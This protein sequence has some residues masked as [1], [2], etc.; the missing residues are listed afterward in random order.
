VSGS[1][2][3]SI[4]LWEIKDFERSTGFGAS[5]EL[6]NNGDLEV[7]KV[8]KG[9]DADQRGLRE[10]DRIK[11]ASIERVRTAAELTK[12]VSKADF[13]ALAETLPA[14]QLIE[15]KGT[16][17]G[18]EE[19]SFSTHKRQSPTLSLF[20]D[21]T[22]QEWI[23]WEPR[24]NYAT[25]I[26]GDSRY[27]G[28][29]QNQMKAA[30]QNSDRFSDTEKTVF[31]SI[32][33][34]KQEFENRV[35][36]D[37]LVENKPEPEE[38]QPPP[39]LFASPVIET[40]G[41]DVFIHLPAE[42]DNAPR[43]AVEV[44]VNSKSLQVDPPN[45]QVVWE[46]LATGWRGKIDKEI[47]K[48]FAPNARVW[49][50]R[51]DPRSPSDAVTVDVEIQAPMTGRLVVFGCGAAR[52]IGREP[53]V[54]FAERDVEYLA[55]SLVEGDVF[56]KGGE[57]LDS[58]DQYLTPS[59]T[60]EGFREAFDKLATAKFQEGDV[61]LA[62][63]E[64]QTHFISKDT[65]E[66]LLQDSVI[67]GESV[68]TKEFQDRL[69]TIA[70]TGCRVFVFLD[71][72]HD[73]L[74]RDERDLR[75][76]WIRQLLDSGVSCFLASQI[77]PSWPRF[78]DNRNPA[79]KHRLFAQSI[80]EVFKKANK[81][82]TFLDFAKD[83]RDQAETIFDKKDLDSMIVPIQSNKLGPHEIFLY[84]PGN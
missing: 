31:N 35:F 8:I 75:Q 2:D 71:D 3:Q 45:S 24:G 54:K 47:L 37:G 26:R 60:I 13:F 79:W 7:T 84:P 48:P 33:A 53:T 70:S 12:P 4:R 14:D 69:A 62:I 73:T 39:H 42:G 83:V 15:L 23:L 65:G 21:Q 9:S 44:L 51:L 25:S 41:E 55:K 17:V 43:P 11:E 5:G 61:F 49:A 59:P 68:A 22:K 58:Q 19:L 32:A 82:K 46:H 81:K 56:L 72:I 18:G 76:D 63:L 20:T 64:A 28:W 52:L 36:I 67:N 78:K 10:G 40:R 1:A 50:R 57:P 38:H 66:I 27:L 74:T 80:L 6:R 77:E 34:H 29:H 30:K 16:R